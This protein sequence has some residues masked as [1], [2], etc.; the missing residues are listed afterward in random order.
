MPRSWI[1]IRRRETAVRSAS[2]ELAYS[3]RSSIDS[4]SPAFPRRTKTGQARSQGL[5]VTPIHSIDLKSPHGDKQPG[6][7]R[8]GPVCPPSSKRGTGRNGARKYPL[9]T[10]TERQQ[11]GVPHPSAFFAEGGPQTFP[12]AAAST[13]R[14]TVN[15]VST[16]PHSAAFQRPDR[17]ARFWF[18][19]RS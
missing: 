7:Q 8:E 1:H 3:L 5:Q 2:E 6:A 11:K 13:L 16:T 10:Q 17:C 18:R 14:K 19:L 9:S 15:S 4:G 12:R